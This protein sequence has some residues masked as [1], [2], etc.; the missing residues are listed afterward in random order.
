[1]ST[2]SDAVFLETFPAWLRSLGDDAE[3]M[4]DALTAPPS[5]TRGCAP[6]S[7]A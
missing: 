2:E 4:A 6:S 3:A 7:R 5:P 1:M